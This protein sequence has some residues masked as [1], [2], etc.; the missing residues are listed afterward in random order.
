[1]HQPAPDDIAPPSA[2]VAAYLDHL[3]GAGAAP[4]TLKAY[5][6]DLAQYER[7]LDAAGRSP[8]DADVALVRRYAAYLGSLR[9]APAT[10][11]RKLS[12]VRRLHAWMFVRGKA[13]VDPAAVVPGPKRGRKLPATLNERE[14]GQLLEPRRPVGA[15]RELRDLA[16][17]EVMYGCGLRAAEICALRLRDLDRH[18]WTL[19]V[20]GKGDKQRVVP[21]GRS[22]A[23]ALG[24]YLDRGRSELAGD[25]ACDRLFTSVRGRPLH[26]SDVRRILAE[27][28]R[29][30]GL[31]QRSPH[32]LRHT[33]ATHLLEGGADLRS[34][35]ELLGHASVGTTQ[36]YTHVSVR[37]LRAAH[38]Q[39]HPRG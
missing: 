8:G 4:A 6:A 2:G 33:F 12:A 9:Y 10:A 34:I 38:A 24:R 27:A 5:A 19:R 23:A 25:G 21:V 31:P 26:G 35:Q 29:R 13:P 28:L 32:A 15:A 37:H 17:L 3:R 18:E 7:W 39:A 11:A 22:A 16:M 30:E 1:V 14:M 20:T 36:V